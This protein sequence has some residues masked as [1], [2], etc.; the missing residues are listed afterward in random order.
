MNRDPM[1]KE[2]AAP[3]SVKEDQLEEGNKE[4]VIAH[5]DAAPTNI[6]S[7]AEKR[8]LR[9]IDWRVLPIPIMLVGLSSIDRT[10]I[11]S[12]RV[13]GM[14]AD[15]DLGGNRYNI[16]VSGRWFPSCSVGAFAGATL[17]VACHDSLLYFLRPVRATEQ[18]HPPAY[19]RRSILVVPHSCMG[20]CRHV[21]WVCA[22][23]RPT[24]GFA[25][26]PGSFRRRAQCKYPSMTVPPSH[27]Y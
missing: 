7:S 19:R 2:V 3:S 21:S 10:N 11:A 8:L 20:H 15:L 16:A 18:P 1:D 9:K 17:T 22:E 12:A 6:V 25:P 14:S 27:S 24:H 4:S 13:A 5:I 26:S 23:F